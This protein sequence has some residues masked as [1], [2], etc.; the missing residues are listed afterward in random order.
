MKS[1]KTIGI[2]FTLISLFFII[3]GL[4]KYFSSYKNIGERIYT[5][6][7]IIKIDEIKTNDPDNPKDFITYVEY[8]SNSEMVIGKLNTYSHKYRVGDKLDIYYFLDN[9]EL[10]YAKGSEHLI[11]IFPIIGMAVF[12]IG[13]ALTFRKKVS[14]SV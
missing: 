2:F 5:V 1:I 14:C 4:I 8:E 9:K 13:I 10:V 12:P 7:K 11:L 3:A 6:A